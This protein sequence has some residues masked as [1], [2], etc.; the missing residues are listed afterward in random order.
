MRGDFMSKS[1]NELQEILITVIEKSVKRQELQEK[2]NPKLTRETS[3]SKLKSQVD[4]LKK[5]TL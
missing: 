3:I 4:E 1:I 2:F 5:G